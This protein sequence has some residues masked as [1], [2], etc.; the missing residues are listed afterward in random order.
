MIKAVIFDMYETLIT[1]SCDKPYFSTAMAADANVSV[2]VYR[3]IW[4]KTEQDR[5]IGKL[6]LEEAVSYTLKE[7]GCYSEE[8][9]QNMV[10]KRRAFKK[11]VFNHIHPDI[12]PMLQSIKKLHIRIGLV[13]NCFSEETE[14]IQQSVL[15]P[16]FDAPF[17][18]YEQGVCKPNEEIFKRCVE[19]LNIK[20]DECLYVGDGGSQEL[21]AARK[22][23]MHPLQAVWYLKAGSVQHRGRMNEFIQIENPM[24]V[25][26]YV[27]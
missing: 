7:L 25:I 20:A 2:E 22:L 19:K 8:L 27:K 17:M 16:F 14:Y 15:Y 12:V 1:L 24:D 4:D 9:H 6:T 13:S 11:E 5:T 18:S 23:G 21:E 3:P 26:E 10:N